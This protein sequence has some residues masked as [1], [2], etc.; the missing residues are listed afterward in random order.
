MNTARISEGRQII[1]PEEICG[2]LGLKF[3]DKVLFSQNQ[4]GEVVMSNASSSAIRKA[5]KAFAGAAEALGL[6]NDDDVQALVDE[7]RYSKSSAVNM[8]CLSFEG[9]P[10]F[11]ELHK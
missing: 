5:Q 3:G 2:L 4:D 6:K 7:V 10:A 1:I 11:H 8:K 9:L